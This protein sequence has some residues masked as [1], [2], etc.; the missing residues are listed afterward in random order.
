M[1]PCPDPGGLRA[2]LDRERPD[3]DAH[4]A[5]CPDCGP[6]LAQQS[7]DA[8]LAAEALGAPPPTVDVDAALARFRS[9]VP[10]AITPLAPRRERVPRLLRARAAAVL[11]LLVIVA[12]VLAT[13]AGR[14]GA[15]AL[16]EQFRAE[17]IA[18]VPVD[19]AAVDPATLQSLA[20]VADLDGLQEVQGPQPVADLDEASAIAG[21]MAAPVD[22]GLLPANVT[23]S[24]TVFAQAPQTLRIAFNDRPDVPEILRR[25]VLVIDVPGAAVQAF[26]GAE[27]VPAVVRGEAGT[28]TVTVDGGPSLAEVRDALLSLPGLPPETVAAVRQI[29]DWE[30][31]LPVPVPVGQVTWDETTV[32]GQPALAF[33]DESGL[34]SALVWRDGDRFVG[35]G[36][37]LPLSEARRLAEG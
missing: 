9:Q 18:V 5:T 36:G 25:A 21:F 20:D 14:V 29:E 28:L 17:R 1:T 4:V 3:L 6:R 19:L 13:P 23:G 31:T 10:A 34:G 26:G 32:D 30:T 7:E 27:G 16:L 8:R 12:G 15:S 35:V 33:G 11:V 24:A 22:R 2:N 37:M